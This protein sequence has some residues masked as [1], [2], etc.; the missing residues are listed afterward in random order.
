MLYKKQNANICIIII[1]ITAS[2]P[3]GSQTESSSLTPSVGT[4]VTPV[5]LCVTKWSSWINKENPL[6]MG[7]DYEQMTKE[8]LS[9]FCPGG[10]ITKIEC[11]DAVTH[12]DYLSL[13]EA[14]CTIDGGLICKNMDD[15]GIHCHDY[16]IRY[17]C[18]C[19]GILLLSSMF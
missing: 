11:R 9:E 12:D 7:G 2:Q 15:I 3:T 6:R 4:N 10:N 8:E 1:N 17:M 14:K 19:S 16:E 5:H 13:E 18:Q